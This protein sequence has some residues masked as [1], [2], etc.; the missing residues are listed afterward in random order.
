MTELDAELTPRPAADDH[1]RSERQ[2][3]N[4]TEDIN[5]CSF[6]FPVVGLTATAPAVPPFVPRL[7]E[8]ATAIVDSPKPLSADWEMR[9][10]AANSLEVKSSFEAE[11]KGFSRSQTLLG[12]HVP[13]DHRAMPLLTQLRSD[14]AGLRPDGGFEEAASRF[15]QA[16]NAAEEMLGLHHPLTLSAAADLGACLTDLGESGARVHRVLVFAHNIFLNRF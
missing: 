12:H 10:W 15:R 3:P 9:A 16:L 7:A 1:D 4:T 5:P 13:T 6:E 2:S 11:A 8:L 14:R